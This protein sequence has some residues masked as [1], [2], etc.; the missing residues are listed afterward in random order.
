MKRKR[1]T[2]LRD[3]PLSKHT[4]TSKTYLARKGSYSQ[5]TTIPDWVVN[6]LGIKPGDEIIWQII[7]NEDEDKPNAVL[8]HRTA[9]VG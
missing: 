6:L 3:G 5:K 1:A 2:D 9:D 7:F 4:E 8:V